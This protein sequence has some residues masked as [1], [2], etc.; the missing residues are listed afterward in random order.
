MANPAPDYS[1]SPDEIAEFLAER[2]RYGS[3]CTLRRDGSPMVDGISWEWDGRAAYF[4]LRDSRA[5]VKRLRV[6]P[7]ACLHVMN[8]DYPPRW[9]RIEGAAEMIDDPRFERTLRIMRRYTSRPLGM[10]TREEFDTEA[11]DDYYF[12][13]GR[14]LV[15]LNVRRL[16]S[17]DGLKQV[18]RFESG[19]D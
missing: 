7:R 19:A 17:W 6:D 5:I 14:T 13:D 11:F 18:S 9:I 3:L 10:Q 4:S 12:A 2:P 8:H 1:M 16:I 15:R